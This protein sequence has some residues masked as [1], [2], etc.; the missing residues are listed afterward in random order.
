MSQPV[1]S[2]AE[3]T[4]RRNVDRS[5]QTRRAL[6]DAGR[7]L[8]AAAGFNRTNTIDIALKAGMTRGAL[9][10][11]FKDKDALF[12]AVFLDVVDRMRRSIRRQAGRIRDPW[13]LFT[14]ACEVYLDECS[15]PV[16]Q[17]VALQ[18]AISVLGW[19]RWSEIMSNAVEADMLYAARVAMDAG[20][21]PPLEVLPLTR[22]LAG[23]FRE[24]AFF[25]AGSSDRSAARAQVGATMSEMIGGL[26]DRA[27]RSDVRRPAD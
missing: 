21:F 1:P 12:E 26:H 6:I 14:R 5:E 20:E 16:F 18:E 2:R 27:L 25:V 22:M 11:H 19:H 7:E 17:T 9:Y 8:F 10:H 13:A 3:P 24:A 15:D 23:A 4:R